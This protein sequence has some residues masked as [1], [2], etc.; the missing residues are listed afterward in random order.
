VDIERW[1][2]WLGHVVKI[3]QTRVSKKIFVRKKVEENREI[4]DWDDWKMQRMIY[5]S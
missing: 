3:Y 2:E 4:R 5:E 1:F